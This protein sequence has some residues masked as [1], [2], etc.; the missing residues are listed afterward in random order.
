M[1]C[2][3]RARRTRPKVGTIG[4]VVAAQLGHA[5]PVITRASYIQPD[6]ARAPRDG[7]VLRVLQ[8]GK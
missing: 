8:G 1:G 5:S 6:V 2:G 3:A 7:R 4:P